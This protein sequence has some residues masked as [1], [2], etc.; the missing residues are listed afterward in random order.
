MPSYASGQ[1]IPQIAIQPSASPISTNV[2]PAAGQPVRGANQLQQIAEALAPFNAGLMN[3]AKKNVDLANDRAVSE[4][5]QVDFSGVSAGKQGED[6]NKQFKRVIEQSG[7]SDA[8]NPYYQIAARQNFGRQLGMQYRAA[9]YGMKEQ[10]SDPNNPMS[11]PE[12]SAQAAQ[13]V[14]GN[15]LEGDFYGFTGFH[16][17]AKKADA[18]M[19]M[20]FTEERTKRLESQ[21]ALATKE[22]VMGAIAGGDLETANA[23]WE[24]YQK[25]VTDPLK[26]RANFKGIAVDTLR[27]AADVDDLHNR[28][29]RLAS[30]KYGNQLVSDNTD[31]YGELLQSSDEAR[32]RI[33]NKLE[34]DNKLSAL[35]VSQATKQMY[36]GGLIAEAHRHAQSNGVEIAGGQIDVWAGNRIDELAK[37]HGWSAETTD[38][39]RG[40]GLEVVQQVVARTANMDNIR[41]QQGLVKLQGMI[42]DGRITSESQVWATAGE[43]NIPND[44]TMKAIDY[45][46]KKSG[47][48]GAVMNDSLDKL[49]QSNSGLLAEQFNV[50]GSV[51]YG[52]DGKPTPRGA[53]EAT[54]HATAINE[55]L[56]RDT[57]DFMTGKIPDKSGKFYQ[58]Y[59]DIS[60][61]EGLFAIRRYMSDR[62]DVL[63]KDA[64][65]RSDAASIAG[66]VSVDGKWIPSKQDTASTT[67]SAQKSV[68][69]LVIQV[70][71]GTASLT[72]GPGAEQIKSQW[73]GTMTRI[74]KE[75]DMGFFMGTSPNLGEG[76]KAVAEALFRAYRENRPVVTN[77]GKIGGYIMA[78]LA[79]PVLTVALPF[80]GSEQTYASFENANRVTAT[81]KDATQILADYGEVMR[82]GGL[83]LQDVVNDRDSLGIKVFGVVIPNDPAEMKIA[84]FSL[85]M[86]SSEYELKDSKLVSDVLKKFGLTDAEAPQ[87]IQA[88]RILLDINRIGRAKYEEPVWWGGVT[89]GQVQE[90]RSAYWEALEL[91]KWKAKN[92]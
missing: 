16:E 91:A 74:A 86:I 23:A 8:A 6:L 35:A 57:T 44:D 26:V 69:D 84:A 27:G 92:Q 45:F 77:D 22:T 48:A 47:P 7:A 63:I 54:R 90:A 65:E 60:Q 12:A 10:V 41:G 67:W 11:Y 53:L 80:V 46:S 2:F 87:F 59:L 17:V 30:M 9:I 14:I 76:R 64:F 24:S 88:Q 1:N 55:Q 68:H 18:E 36:A 4:G 3:Y 32:S 33:Y 73:T 52:V 81:Q 83:T 50:N 34:Q 62:N 29:D 28:F 42:A 75:Y 56:T 82:M 39:M 79:S 66:K 31:L 25:T 43:L 13:Q 71:D 49:L 21:G 19:M 51:A 15:T 5:E 78:A 70:S 85:P 89:D 58:Q 20:M 40:I 61:Q 37:E 38:Q 72:S